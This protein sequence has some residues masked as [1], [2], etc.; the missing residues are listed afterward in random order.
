MDHHCPWIG[1]QCVG[2]AN[3]GHFLRFLIAVDL[4]MCYHLAMMCW[5][6]RDYAHYFDNPSTFDVV[7]TILNFAVGVPV[8]LCVGLFSLYHIYCAASNSTTIEGWEKDRVATLVR[9]GKIEEIK[10][11]YVRSQLCW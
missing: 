10:Y 11:P 7:I 5:R 1:S 9:R 2:Y 6:V 3:V 4:A 8:W